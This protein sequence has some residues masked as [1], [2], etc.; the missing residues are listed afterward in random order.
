[1]IKGK[2]IY[3]K[4]CKTESLTVED[5]AFVGL[6]SV[7]VFCG[8]CGSKYRYKRIWLL[9]TDFIRDQEFSL[10]RT[11]VLTLGLWLIPGLFFL[12]L[13]YALR[14]LFAGTSPVKLAKR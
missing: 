10:W 6:G 9:L 2:V 13:T 14:F 4:V 7:E 11:T 3:C 1:M 12:G 8:N 5:P